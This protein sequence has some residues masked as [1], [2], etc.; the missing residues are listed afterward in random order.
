MIMVGDDLI[1]VRSRLDDK[2]YVKYFG[3]GGAM[4]LDKYIESQGLN[5]KWGMYAP[6]Y[7][8]IDEDQ[9]NEKEKVDVIKLKLLVN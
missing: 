2:L 8:H 7:S 1:V 9:L 6:S 5:E 4:E 3:M